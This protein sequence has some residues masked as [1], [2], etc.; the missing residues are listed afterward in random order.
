VR[1]P[2]FALIVQV[3]FFSGSIHGIEATGNAYDQVH[4]KQGGRTMIATFYLWRW[5]DNE[6]P[7][8]PMEVL[9]AMMR[10]ELHPALQPFG[11]R[12]VLAELGG[13]SRTRGMDR[14]WRLVNRSKNDCHTFRWQLSPPAGGGDHHF[15]KPHLR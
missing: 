4:S 10:G 2:L 15:I 7:G 3:P 8:R 1:Y 12:P 11:A 14:G 9:A 5:E 13:R 6:L